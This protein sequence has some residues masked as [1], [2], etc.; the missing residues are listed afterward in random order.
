[1]RGLYEVLKF[2][3]DKWFRL[4]PRDDWRQNA[5]GIQNLDVADVVEEM[6]SHRPYRPALG[7]DLA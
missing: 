2:T 5:S 6:S 3:G 4:S 7:I 1:V